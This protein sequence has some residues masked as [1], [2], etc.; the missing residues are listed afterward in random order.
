VALTDEVLSWLWHHHVG[1]ALA[2]VASA[3]SVSNDA[4]EVLTR[5][6]RGTKLHFVINHGASP[7]QCELSRPAA[8][9]L[10]DKEMSGA[11]EVEGYGY[12]ILVE[13]S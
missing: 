1:A 5:T 12:R 2:S 10:S 8:D 13:R 3:V 11:F 4:A 9:L 7:V 6:R